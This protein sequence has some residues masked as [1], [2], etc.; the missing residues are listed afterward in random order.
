VLPDF[1]FRERAAKKVEY[2]LKA[3][4]GIKTHTSLVPPAVIINDRYLTRAGF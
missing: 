4:L 1:P 3:L 2:F